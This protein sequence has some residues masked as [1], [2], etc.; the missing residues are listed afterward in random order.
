VVAVSL[1]LL[2]LC[3]FLANLHSLLSLCH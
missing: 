3:H 2:R 1:V